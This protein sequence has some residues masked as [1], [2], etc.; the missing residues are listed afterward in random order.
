MEAYQRWYRCQG[1]P[2]LLRKENT[3]TP[4]I[5][6]DIHLVAPMVEYLGPEA[7]P[8]KFVEGKETP[9]TGHRY[10]CKL[11]DPK[12]KNCTIYDIRPQMCRDYPGLGGCNFAACTWK[13]KKRKK[14]PAIKG[15][16]LVE[17]GVEEDV[18]E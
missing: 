1:A 3:S 17:M 9:G 11:W 6:R 4:L 7:K 18:K 16:D 14:T 8:P 15:S 2:P 13:S 12:T 10:R 5:D